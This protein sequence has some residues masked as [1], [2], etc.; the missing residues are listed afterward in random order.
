M[1]TDGELDVVTGATGYTGKYITRRLLGQGRRV[2][3]LTGHLN[4]ENPFGGRVELIPYNFNAPNVLTASLEGATTLYNT[5]WVRFSHG[6]STFN[7]AVEN[8]QTLFRAAKAAGVK[9]VVPV[10]I[11]NPDKESPLPHYRGKAV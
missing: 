10:S 7:T 3:S 2:K 1:G 6:E 9:N 8:T 5:Y 11:A 4:R